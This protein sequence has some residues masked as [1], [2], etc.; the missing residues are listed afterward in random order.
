MLMLSTTLRFLTLLLLV[1]ERVGE[2]KCVQMHSSSE[3]TGDEPLDYPQE[4]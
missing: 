4:A 2:H 1:R 3:Y